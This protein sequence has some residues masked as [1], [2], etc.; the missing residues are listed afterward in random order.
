MHAP[1]R[2]SA[3]TLIE[4]LVAFAVFAILAAIAYGTLGQ[5]LTN[6]EVLTERMQ[7][8]QAVQRTMRYLGEDFMQL[9][10]RPIRQ[11]LGDNLGPALYAS[12]QSNFAVELTHGGWSNPAALPRS[13][14]QRAA[15]R[16]E[17]GELLRYHWTV[18][19]RTLS[20]EPTVRALLDD[21]ESIQFNFMQENGDW[22][23]QWPPDDRPGVLGLRQRPRAVEIV[24]TLSDTTE[25]TRLLEVAP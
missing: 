5:T 21:V 23:D 6:S 20:N 22:T 11:D 4:L 8:L 13:T 19:D 16:L 12:V 7:R 2:I 9:A 25:I 24:L 17:D 15:Y 14:L 1:A 3:F 10:P 18:L